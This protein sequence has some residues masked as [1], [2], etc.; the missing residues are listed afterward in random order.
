M[1][2]SPKQAVFEGKYDQKPRNHDQ[3]W[4]KPG[5]FDEFVV[6]SEDQDD[7]NS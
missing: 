4:K 7:L 1:L 5:K 3:K 6:A 2:S